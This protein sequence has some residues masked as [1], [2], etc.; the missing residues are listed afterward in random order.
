[1]NAVSIEQTQ[2]TYIVAVKTETQALDIINTACSTYALQ[3]FEISRASLEDTFVELIDK[4]TG[5]NT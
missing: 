4:K 1:L 2:H 5:I 3:Q